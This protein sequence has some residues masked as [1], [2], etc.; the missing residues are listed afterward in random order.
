MAGAT[1][2]PAEKALGDTGRDTGLD[3]VVVSYRC[4]ELLRTCL[5]SLRAHPPGVPVRA[6]VVDNDSEDGTVEMVRSDFPDVELIA[7]PTNLGFAAATNLGAR[8]GSAPYLLVLNPDTA[9]TEGALDTVLD[10]IASRPEVAVA[11]PRLVLEDGSLDHA[12]KLS[13]RISM[14]APFTESTGPESVSGA[15]YAAS[16]PAAPGRRPSPVK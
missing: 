5:D 9:V 2:Q 4:R 6:I 13:L 16:L 3:V 1:P 7:A 11:G 15:R 12:S 10:A 8:R 14:K